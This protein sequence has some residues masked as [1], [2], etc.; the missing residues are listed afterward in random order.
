M[1]ILSFISK[2][3]GLGRRFSGTPEQYLGMVQ[4]MAFKNNPEFTA[5]ELLQWGDVLQ[6]VINVDLHPY[7]DFQ[8]LAV[9]GKAD[10]SQVSKVDE[11]VKELEHRRDLK[12]AIYGPNADLGDDDVMKSDSESAVY[13]RI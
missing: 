6:K 1:G 9:N 12:K 8:D 10:L 7:K 5:A 4:Y 13:A 11:K 3:F 2:L